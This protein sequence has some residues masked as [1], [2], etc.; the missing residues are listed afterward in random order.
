MK[1]LLDEH[2][3]P[4]IARQLRDRGPDVVAAKERGELCGLSDSELF[5]WALAEDRVVVTENVRDFVPLHEALLAQG[6]PHPGVVFA[7]NQR[8][9]RGKP[10]TI[11]ALVRALDALL[12]VESSKRLPGSIVWL[13]I[14]P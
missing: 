10:A 11:G 1:L 7:S 2:F 13:D 8:F 5:A 9:P 4:V 6:R 14:R 12:T 3:P